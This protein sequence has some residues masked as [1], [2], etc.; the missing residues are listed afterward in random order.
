MRLLGLV[1]MCVLPL[2]A[3]AAAQTVVYKC[4]DD[5]GKVVFQQVACDESQ[6][7]GDSAAHDV[8]RKMRALSSEGKNALAALGADVESIKQ[9]NRA[10]AVFNGKVEALSPAVARVARQ[11]KDLAKAH[12]YLKD[13]GVCR[14]SA[15]AN[16]R[17]ADKYLDQAVSKLTEY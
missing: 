16:C 10:I 14:T 7:T 15:E 8:W 12:T 11:H 17:T 1:F 2:L 6:V 5:R 9:C 4:R 3:Q 13:C